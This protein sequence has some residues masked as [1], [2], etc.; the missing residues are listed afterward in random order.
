MSLAVEVRAAD[1]LSHSAT[2]SAVGEVLNLQIWA[3]ISG[4]NH[5]AAQDGLQDLGGSFVGDGVGPGPVAGDLAGFGLAPFNANGSQ[6]GTQQDLNGDGNV[7]VGSNDDSQLT[8]FFFARSG[9]LE[10]S[11]TVVSGNLSFQVGTLTYTVSNLNLGGEVDITFAPWMPPVSALGFAA[12]WREDNQPRD[13]TNGVFTGGTPFIITA[14]S[15]QPTGPNAVDDAFAATPAVPVDVD[16]LQ[17]DFDNTGMLLRNSIAVVSQPN[18]GGDIAIDSTTGVVTYTA[19]ADFV[20]S[21]TFSYTVADDDGLTSPPATVTFTVTRADLAAP[22]ANDDTTSTI[23]G[24]PTSVD[25]LS[26]DGASSPALPD[27]LRVSVVTDAAHGSTVVDVDGSIL[28][29]PASDFVGADSF[30]YAFVDTNG[31]TSN[32]ATVQV[33]VGVAISLAAAGRRSLSFVDADGTTGTV[34]LT[35]GTAELHFSGTGSATV[36][37]R[38]GAVRVLALAGSSL[39]LSDLSLSGASATSILAIIGRGGNGALAL[40]NLTASGQAVGRI[41]APAVD[42]DGVMNVGGVGLLSLRRLND[43]QIQIGS[44]IPAGVSIVLGDVTATS[45]TS[46]VPIRLLRVSS[47]TDPASSAIHAPVLSSLLSLG[48]FATGLTLSGSGSAAPT[49]GAARIGGAMRGGAWSITGNTSALVAKSITSTWTGSFNGKLG[50]LL[51]RTGGLPGS[52]TATGAINALLVIGDLTGRVS[53]GSIRNMLVSGAILNTTVSS[54]GDILSMAAGSMSGATITAGATPG[55][56]LGA[57]TI[58]AL[59]ITGRGA[60]VFSDTSIFAHRITAAL[61]GAVNTSSTAPTGLTAQAFGTIIL[62][63]NA[64]PVVLRPPQLSSQATLD[65]YLAS[66]GFDLG[67]VTIQI[68]P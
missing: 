28:Y 27:P 26:N 13:N 56:D 15:A 67:T 53:A 5:V 14:P 37:A 54:A 4:A 55:V 29:S 35:R 58:G 16:V 68:A 52:L 22:L 65:A 24:T 40:G 8:G 11:G 12:V 7:D 43:A 60:N 59:R 50:A 3:T 25:V 63:A 39:A 9:S 48:D 42:F 23:L 17:N 19:A 21:E 62:I 6:A 2:V 30:T 47:W 51:V 44:A 45:L 20:G 1:G 31:K 36:A 64:K 38:T 10:T 46:A 49:L 18:H 57:R 32:T 34:V 66:K 33:N 41:L 61:L